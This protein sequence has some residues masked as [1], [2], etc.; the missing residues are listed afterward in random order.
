MND[1]ALVL[2]LADQTGI[3]IGGHMEY[4]TAAVHLGQ[5]S[6][7]ANVCAHGAGS[8]MLYIHQ[9]THGAAALLECGCHAGKGSLLHQ[10]DHAGRSKNGQQAAAHAGGG[11]GFGNGHSGLTLDTGFEFHDKFPPY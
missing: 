2:A 9:R 7:G 8:Q 4:Q 3:V 11:V 6:L 5:L 1:K 10:C